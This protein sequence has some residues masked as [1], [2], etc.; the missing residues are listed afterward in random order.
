M[1]IAGLELHSLSTYLSQTDFASTD[2]YAA[3]VRDHIAIGMY[4]RCCRSYDDLNEGDIG[5]VVQLD[6]DGEVLS[7]PSEFV[8]LLIFFFKLLVGFSRWGLLKSS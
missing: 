7:P 8:I 4:V 5:P 6:R 1:I 2:D 3:Y